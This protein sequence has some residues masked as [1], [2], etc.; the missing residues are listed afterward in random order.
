MCGGQTVLTAR[1]SHQSLP[2]RHQALRRQY[3]GATR[4]NICP[5]PVETSCTNNQ[6]PVCPLANK[7]LPACR[8]TLRGPDFRVPRPAA[9]AIPMP[10]QRSK[11][12]T[13]QDVFLPIYSQHTPAAGPSPSAAL[14]RSIA[15]KPYAHSKG[16]LGTIF[17]TTIIK[18]LDSSVRMT[19]LPR[20][21]RISSMRKIVILGTDTYARFNCL[22]LA[23]KFLNLHGVLRR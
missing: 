7:S 19:A 22:I 14:P 20:I 9:Y 11:E 10:T 18:V 3:F 6:V 8:S 16:C 21:D 12:P 2:Q 1:P 4:S 15:L 17:I 13:L 23:S 5:L